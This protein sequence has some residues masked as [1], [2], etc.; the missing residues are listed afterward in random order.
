[1]SIKEINSSHA[2][3]TDKLPL[4]T[5]I[6]YSFGE[7]GSQCSWALISSYLT[8]FYTD[9]VGL[10]PVV[11]SVIMLI[12]RIWDTINDP[13][14]GAI[15]ENTKTKWGRFRPYILWGAPILALFNCLTFLNMDIPN[16]WK[17][18]WCAVT[19]I[20]CGMAYTAVNIST[21][22]VANCMT[23][24]NKER[25]S[26]NAFKGVGSCVIQI[27]I[28][29]TT[30][31][32]ILYFGN[33][34]ASSPK[35]YFMS[36]LI[37]SIISVPCFWICF[38]SS[39]EVLGRKD[40]SK[41]ETISSTMKNLVASF[42][43]TFKDRNAV[44]LMLAMVFFLT[45]LFGRIGIMAYY[46]IYILK[47]AAL[48]ATFATAMSI[49]NLLTNFFVPGL[50]NNFSKKYVG[51]LGCICQALCCVFFFIIGENHLTGMVVISGFLYGFTNVVAIATNT[52]SAEI[53][54]DNWLRTGVRSDGVIQS[55]VSFSQKFGNAIGGSI[56][57]LALSAV[58][59]VANSENLSQ[60]ILT[61]MDMVINFAPAA[62][63]VIAAIMFISISLNK[64]KSKMN[65]EKI[66]LML[67]EGKLK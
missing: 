28:S 53:I 57:I 35:G 19:Y 17:S 31:P 61:R 6:G 23:A 10:T 54:D 56:G 18:I 21:Q 7:A 29:A 40:S 45:G 16:M 24:S 22:C 49:G 12:A 66:T 59:Y 25:V 33:G 5:K 39:K 20:G 37:F 32:L 48:M 11:I 67:A 30:M 52:L 15:A 44:L 43:F 27:I 2:E 8:I 1:M 64:A 14:F 58:G 60:T 36:A 13:M 26:L 62:F 3:N 50:L 51:A 55:C 46:F 42:K 47:D 63:Y 4:R 38:A 41:K 65:E 34:S 9:V